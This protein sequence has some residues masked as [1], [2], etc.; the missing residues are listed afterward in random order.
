MDWE[1]PL[2][3]LAL[4]LV[5]PLM[6]W[7]SERSVHPMGNSRKRALLIVRAVIFSLAVICLAG[8][9][10]R[11]SSQDE[12]VIFIVDYSESL[13][14]KG[15]SAA[16]KKAVDIASTLPSGAN[17]GFVA[18]GSKGVVLVEPSVHWEPP[19]FDGKIMHDIGSQTDIAEALSLA[20]GLFPAG[21]AR[22]VVIVSDGVQTRGDLA[23]AAQY[24]SVADI[25]V[26]CAPIAGVARPDARVIKITP[27]RSR[28]HEGATIS[29]STEIESSINGEGVLRLFENGIEVDRAD[30][31]LKT[32]EVKTVDFKRTPDQRNLYT[33]RVR[34]EGFD[35]DSIPDNNESMTLVD[36]RGRPVLLYIEGEPGEAHYLAEAM[37]EEGILLESRPPEAIPQTIEALGGY[38][39][40]IFSDIPAHLVSTDTMNLIRDYVEQLGGGFM[41][42]GGKNSFGVGGYYRTPIE[43]ILPVKMKS[44]DK[45]ERF[46]TALVLVIDRSGSM[47]GQ[48]I[49]ICKSAAIGTADLLSAKDYIGVVAFDSNANWVVPMTKVSSKSAIASQIATINSGGGTNIHPGMTA[50]YD[51]LRGVKA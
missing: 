9:A 4:P 20:S 31:S 12:A 39:G 18:A 42:I 28:S 17:V 13:G 11:K 47:S 25:V 23:F 3:L 2:I 35:G 38:D 50:G 33:Y 45:E 49:E 6:W 8:P 41:M 19:V 16:L 10:I 34:L 22:R 26:D 51:A 43:D 44:P 21:M 40:I 29:L 14:E 1:Y 5:L 27:S 36:V 46:S 15:I 32:G 24:A 30:V 48:K 37:G 7:W